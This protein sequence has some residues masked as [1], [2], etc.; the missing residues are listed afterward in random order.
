MKA[1]GGFEGNAQTLR[2]L[3]RLEKKERATTQEDDSGFDTSGND[4]RLG[5][6]SY[7]AIVG[8]GTE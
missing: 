1:H 5:L 6:E 8:I 4:Q 2:I 7:S 3:C